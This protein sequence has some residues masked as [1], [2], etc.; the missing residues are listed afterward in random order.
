MA[1]LC[2]IDAF[3]HGS[4]RAGE[5]SNTNPEPQFR[6]L[7]KGQT[8]A[9]N[10]Q[11][12]NQGPKIPVMAANTL[13]A[14]F[15]AS[16]DERVRTLGA[17]V[18]DQ[19]KTHTASIL[20]LKMGILSVLRASAL[21]EEQRNKWVEILETAFDTLLILP[22]DIDFNAALTRVEDALR[23]VAAFV[24]PK[25]QGG[26]KKDG[27]RFPKAEAG[28]EDGKR[29]ELNAWIV[30][31]ED[32]AH[33]S[34]RRWEDLK[35]NIESTERLVFLLSL[36]PVRREA[37]MPPDIENA[38]A[39]L[40]AEK[41]R[42]EKA[43]ADPTCEEAKTSERH[44]RDVAEAKALLKLSRDKARKAENSRMKTATKKRLSHLASLDEPDLK[45]VLFAALRGENI[46]QVQA[47]RRQIKKTGRKLDRAAKRARAIADAYRNLYR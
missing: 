43:K 13:A 36:G 3:L 14:I 4:C 33:K 20:G 1:I 38:K 47:V 15:E 7:Q 32:H 16:P 2:Y 21:E 10:K 29:K 12:Q 5:S 6:Q 40:K 46:P 37:A 26:K 17:P 25:S 42:V 28:L 8:M 31:M 22:I 9:K 27:S 18:R 19:A 44:E 34:H 39:I 23:G 35:G 24:L 45:R 41:A 30:W 11:N